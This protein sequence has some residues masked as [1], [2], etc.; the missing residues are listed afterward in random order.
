MAD[1][2]RP[3][4][5]NPESANAAAFSS[6]PAL[7]ELRGISRSYGDLKATDD[8]DLAVHAGRVHAVLGQNGAGK[9]TLMNI[10]AGVLQPDSGQIL[11]QGTPTVFRGAGD[12]FAAGI[13]M[14]HQHFQLV[15]SMTVAENLLLNDEPHRRGLVDRRRANE[16]AVESLRSLGTDIDPDRRVSELSVGARQRIEIARVLRRNVRVLVLDEPT[17]VL[18]PVEAADLMLLVRRM[19]DNGTA[20]LLISHKLDEVLSVTDHVTVL[21]AGRVV[22]DQSAIGLDAKELAR[23][24]IGRE[25]EMTSNALP[26]VG[27]ERSVLRLD[28]ISTDPGPFGPAL[29]GAHLDLRAGQIHGIA[30]VDGNGQ[31]ELVAVMTG[32]AAPAD[33]Q[34]FWKGQ[35]VQKVS[36]RQRIDLGVG[37]IPEDRHEQGLFLDENIGVNLVMRRLR[38]VSRYGLLHRRRIR[39]LAQ[40][41]VANFQIR[42]RIER[43]TRELSGGNQQKVVLARELSGEAE[44]I[45]AEQPTRG[46]DVASAQF[47]Y[48][49]LLRQRDA[50]KAVV[51]ISVD[52][53]ELLNLAD[54]IS[55]IYGGR[56]VGSWPRA[57]FDV[58]TMAERMT[59]IVPA[60]AVGGDS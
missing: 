13:G 29:Q 49:Q 45:I 34:V 38:S 32:A 41:M 36:V 1:S 23:M 60:S 11:V 12:A 14:V 6:R 18:A 56:I 35:I 25:V 28:D 7:V 10:L 42:G 39:D 20:V 33:G 40:H 57:S 58:Q 37:H 19:A 15:P 51:V 50:G 16:V 53:D 17:A 46:V 24:M 59:G 44:L 54:H 22:A 47:I 26:A 52:L 8:V 4:R 2:A 48:S 43:P 9:S 3:V 5:N 31:R 27:K 30:G 55:V 21:R